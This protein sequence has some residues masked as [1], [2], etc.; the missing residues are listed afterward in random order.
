[1]TGKKIFISYAHQDAAEAGRLARALRS[2]DHDVWLDTDS[3]LPGQEWKLEI[4]KAV[5]ESDVFIALLSRWSSERGYVQKELRLALE[6]LDEIPP[7]QVYIIPARLTF[8]GNSY[9]QKLNDLNWVDLFPSFDAGVSKIV[10]AIQHAAGKD[11]QNQEREP[12]VRVF[13]ARWYG[14]DAYAE[15]PDVTLPPDL[16]EE[17]QT[18]AVWRACDD[19]HVTVHRLAQII[20]REPKKI[21]EFWGRSCAYQFDLEASGL[22]PWV[23]VDEIFVRVNHYTPLPLYRSTYP[24]P[25]Y[26]AHVYYVEIDDPAN[27]GTSNFPATSYY[28]GSGERKVGM[29]RL[30][31]REPER[32]VLR[33]N[34]LTSGV[35]D[36]SVGLICSYG[37]VKAELWVVEN[38]QC[39]FEP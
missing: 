10:A 29:L 25:F 14:G 12:A 7:G 15:V 24:Q 27:A 13:A 39:F 11:E 31:P 5:R 32:F 17:E 8:Y 37:D 28:G 23:I 1:M 20:E 22:H 35:Y 3:L 26:E 38:E 34:A 19:G 9:H 33:I 30:A 4:E 36:Y 21:T 6:V 18:E 2:E 16:D